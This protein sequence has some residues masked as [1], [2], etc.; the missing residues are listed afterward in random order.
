MT[1]W[2]L[3]TQIKFFSQVSS[4]LYYFQVVRIGN[5][6]NFIKIILRNC[7]YGNENLFPNLVKDGHVGMP[8]SVEENVSLAATN[9]ILVWLCH[10]TVIKI[11]PKTCEK[12][13]QGNKFRI[14]SNKR[15]PRLSATFERE[16]KLLGA[17]A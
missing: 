8:A 17:A 15:R 7:F 16:K 9:M 1:S 3:D 13:Y 11:V 4:K 2:I 5:I 12:N 6:I 14:Y 10:W